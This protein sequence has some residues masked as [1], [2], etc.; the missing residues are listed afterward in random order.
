[1]RWVTRDHVHL[2]RAAA[3]WLIRRFVDPEADFE[4]VPTFGW[5]GDLPDG[6]TAFGLP[7]VEL[8]S[9]DANGS[10]FRK[11]ARWAELTDPAVQDMADILEDAIALFLMRI[12]KGPAPAAPHPAA[13]GLIA[14]A[15]GMA[16]AVRDDLENVRLSAPL[17]EA[18]Y[19]H[20]QAARALQVRPDL[21]GKAP[22]LIMD[23]MRPL[24]GR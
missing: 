4:F 24:I 21:A 19:A 8:S 11:I 18:L 2:D 10:T 20:C 3:T 16:Y 5:S 14:I 7:L 22:H 23:Q 13:E 12:G 6:A 17:Y 1:V 9:H 15:E